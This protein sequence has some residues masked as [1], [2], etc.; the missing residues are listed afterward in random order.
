MK[1]KTNRRRFLKVLVGAGAALAISGTSIYYFMKN[2]EKKVTNNLPPG[3]YETNELSVLTEGYVPK[4]DEKTWVFEVYGLVENHLTF[5]Y[6]QF[7]SLPKTQSV[8]NFHCVTG[9]SKLGNIWEGVQF[10][11]IRKM[12][13]PLSNAKFATI[14]C[15]YNGVNYTTSLPI[16]D[17]SRDD[18]LFAYRLDGK[19][20][21]PEH[22]GPL[23]IVVPEKYGYK[24]AKWVIKVKFTEAQEL[25]FWETQGYSNTA[26]PFKDDRYA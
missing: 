2:E 20:L 17:L 3:Q 21:A 14:E 24:S 25:G 6:E 23:R 5:N 1:P 19:E 15:E 10:G 18:V 4:F 13:V 8:S 9:W 22:G 7:R 16:E 11:T 26:D 12:A